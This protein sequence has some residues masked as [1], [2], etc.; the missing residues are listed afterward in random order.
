MRTPDQP[1]VELRPGE[2]AE[3]T[4]NG[5]PLV[6]AGVDTGAYTA[7]KKNQLVFD[8]APLREVARLIEDQYGYRVEITDPRLPD[9]ELTLKL[10]QNDLDILLQSLEKLFGLKAVRHEKTITLER[11]AAP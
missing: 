6:R 1:R 8:H 2:L 11:N 9:E 7:W 3:V 10:P 5:K 4:Q